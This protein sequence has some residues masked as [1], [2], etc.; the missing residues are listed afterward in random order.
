MAVIIISKSFEETFNFGLKFA[1]TITP[2]TIIA[3]F[4]DLGSGKTSLIKGIV[5]GLDSN[6]L[7]TSPTFAYLNI[8]NSIFP[9]YHFDL[10]RIKNIN[11]FYSMGFQEYFN[12]DGVCLFEWAEKILE[13]LPKNSIKIKIDNINESE[14]KI[15]ITN[16]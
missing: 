16:P 6:N 11:D 9:V 10:Y 15:I 7:V 2:G 8:Y 12:S 14:R 5:K 13:I 4:G 3:F 1:K